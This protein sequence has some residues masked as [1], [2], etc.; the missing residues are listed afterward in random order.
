[1]HRLK[2]GRPPECAHMPHEMF[3]DP[4]FKNLESLVECIHCERVFSL[5]DA[6]WDPAWRFWCCA[7]PGCSGTLI[8]FVPAVRGRRRHPATRSTH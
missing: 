1:M 3:A 2:D 5:G 8:D 7:Y 6:V 4:F